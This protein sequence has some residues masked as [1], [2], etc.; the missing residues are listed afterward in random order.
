M[1]LSSVRKEVRAEEVLLLSSATD[2]ATGILI[3]HDSSGVAGLGS[4]TWYQVRSF[5]RPCLSEG[6]S[7]RVALLAQLASGIAGW[8]VGQRTSFFSRD[9]QIYEPYCFARPS[10]H[11]A[12]LL[13]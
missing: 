7:I 2:D 12:P 5:L 4:S 3:S 10:S 6:W 9:P 11:C 1:S 8:L 13:L